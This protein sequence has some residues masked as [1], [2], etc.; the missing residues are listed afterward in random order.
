MEGKIVVLFLIAL[1]GGLGGGFGLS[2]IVYQPQ[3]Q[4]LLKTTTNLQNTIVNL[5]STLQ[6]LLNMSGAGI[7]NQVQM[8]GAIQETITGK[9]YLDETGGQY[10]QTF[11]LIVNGQYSVLL[12][13]GYS[14]N[15]YIYDSNGNSKGSYSIY[16]PSGV[17]TFTANF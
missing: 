10:I 14:Y 11:S 2:Y 5:N 7:N 17:T 6:G 12:V 3:I 4:S 15:V 8:S 9:V 1:I 16:V 13:G